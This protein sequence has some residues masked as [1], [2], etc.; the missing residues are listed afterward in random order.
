M[1]HRVKPTPCS[2]D[3][4]C[5]FRV[6]RGNQPPDDVNRPSGLRVCSRTR[7]NCVCDTGLPSL[8]TEQRR[9][10]LR[11]SPAASAQSSDGYAAS[12]KLSKQLRRSR[13][14]LTIARDNYRP[15]QVLSKLF[16]SNLP[17]AEK[18][19]FFLTDLD[20]GPVPRQCQCG[21]FVRC[22]AGQDEVVVSVDQDADHSFSSLQARI[23]NGVTNREMVHDLS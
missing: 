20:D 12:R 13:R 16:R 7:S 15:F 2:W 8:S 3:V 11:A 21:C 1:R 22:R 23:G 4:L 10:S 9:S 17:L 19:G 18:R 14:R 6:V 5:S